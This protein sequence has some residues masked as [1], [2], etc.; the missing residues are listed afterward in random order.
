[1]VPNDINDKGWFG[2][3]VDANELE[4]GVLFS[5]NLAPIWQSNG[6]VPI[7]APYNYAH[8]LAVH[9][10][11][12]QDEAR[13]KED[14]EHSLTIKICDRNDADALITKM[15]ANH[16]GPRAAEPQVRLQLYHLY[17]GSVILDGGKPLHI[18]DDPSRRTPKRCEQRLSELLMKAKFLVGASD[19]AI[20]ENIEGEPPNYDERDLLRQWIQKLGYRRT[21]KFGRTGR[22]YTY[23]DAEHFLHAYAK[24]IGRYLDSPTFGVSVDNFQ[25][26]TLGKAFIHN[27]TAVTS[28]DYTEV[29]RIMQAPRKADR[30][31]Q[32]LLYFRM[33]SAKERMDLA[34]ELEAALP[35]EDVSS[36]VSDWSNMLVPLLPVLFDIRGCNPITKWSDFKRCFKKVERA[37]RATNPT[38]STE[39]DGKLR[40]WLMH[41]FFPTIADEY[42]AWKTAAP[43]LDLKFDTRAIPQLTNET[44]TKLQ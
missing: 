30:T 32:S 44:K 37:T 35:S 4:T 18:Y 31:L 28:G 36:D 8:Q 16:T 3:H 38:R 5:L 40:L 33:N 17:S 19:Y 11:V 22:T 10:L 25:N 24:D 13:A 15:T 12:I 1:M 41:R 27:L 2:G 29:H 9:A 34:E 39:L 14:C 26:T 42:A 7:Y 23:P 20:Q 6:S 43:S 21:S